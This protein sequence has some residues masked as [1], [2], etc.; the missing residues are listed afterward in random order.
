MNAPGNTITRLTNLRDL[1]GLPLIGGGTTHPGVLYRGDALHPGDVEPDDVRPWPPAVVIDLR[2]PEESRRVGYAWPTGPIVHNHPLHD[3]AAP[4]EDIPD[5]LTGVY[6]KIVNTT[7]H[8]IAATVALTA[9]AEGP[10]FV[11]CT[12]GK[13]RTGLV[14]AALLLS[15]GVEP[16]AVVADYLATEPNMPTLRDKLR[17]ADVARSTPSGRPFNKALLDVTEEGIRFVV[18]ILETWPGGPSGWMRDHGA[19]QSD[20]DRFRLRFTAPVVPDST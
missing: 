6:Q 3:A 2:T 17:S 9:A 13:D 15:V 10:V 8:R 19:D 5:T 7:P 12:M 18:N 11:H 20:L 1:G 16:E 4:T 14:I